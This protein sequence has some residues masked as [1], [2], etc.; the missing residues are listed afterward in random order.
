MQSRKPQAGERACYD[1]IEHASRDELTAL[2]T[3]RLARTLRHVYDNVPHYRKKFDAAGVHPD[4]FRELKDLASERD[5]LQD[6]ARDFKWYPVLQL[7]MS[8]RF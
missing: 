2:Q 6:K 8:I 4:D 7:G 3:Q 1:P 5:D